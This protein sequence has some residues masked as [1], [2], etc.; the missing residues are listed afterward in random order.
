MSD[1]ASFEDVVHHLHHNPDP[2]VRAEAARLL[3]EHVNALDNAQYEE[4]KIAL[5][6]ALTD[7]DPMV[8]MAAMSALSN[9]NRI[10]S[11]EAMDE[12]NTNDE[13]T[14]A[15]SAAACR[16]CGKPEAL[17]A[18]DECERANCPYKR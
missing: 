16:V 14:E 18:P 9:Y 8:L 6:H 2:S 4:A 1:G 5:S 3:G 12:L 13:E 10:A 11:Q 17:I 15:I 7:P